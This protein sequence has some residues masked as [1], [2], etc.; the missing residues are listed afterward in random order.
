[1][2]D[3][4]K[5]E[6]LTKDKLNAIKAI[7]NNQPLT[8]A[9]M[10]KIKKD[11]NSEYKN[12][13]DIIR[14]KIKKE[15]EINMFKKEE[16]KKYRSFDEK[17]SKILHKSLPYI[18]KLLFKS[19]KNNYDNKASSVKYIDDSKYRSFD[20]KYKFKIKKFN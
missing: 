10:M 9:L 16:M 12:V 13:I 6:D 7:I 14:L 17:K 20:E 11:V 15:K 3:A 8:S 2:K 5:I 1:M 4:K 19:M 18:K